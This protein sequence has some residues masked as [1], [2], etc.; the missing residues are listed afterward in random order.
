MTKH[1]RCC[2]GG[3]VSDLG[4][5]DGVNQW[6]QLTS[7]EELSAAR[8]EAVV[9]LSTLSN[10]EALIKWPWKLVKCQ[11]LPKGDHYSFLSKIV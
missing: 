7:A 10:N 3:N 1:A 9:D 6:Y 4:V 2:V 5:I 8:T 11:Y